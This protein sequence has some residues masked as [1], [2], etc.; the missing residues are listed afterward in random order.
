MKN[1]IYNQSFL[2]GSNSMHI[3]ITEHAFKRVKERT[4]IKP[5]SL[6]RCIEKI[7]KHG[8]SLE[9]ANTSGLIFLLNRYLEDENSYPVIH[10]RYL[11]IFKHAGITEVL[12]TII[13]V[14]KEYYKLI[15]D[16][17]EDPPEAA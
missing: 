12:I 2:A 9:S 17:V 16:E 7:F 15:D 8:I 11:Y 13:P 14:S 5:N 3:I 1:N 10:G 4:G 6:E